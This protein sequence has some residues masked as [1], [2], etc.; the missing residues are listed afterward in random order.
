MF[1]D[2]LFVLSE[3]P[4]TFNLMIRSPRSSLKLAPKPCETAPVHKFSQF[5]FPWLD[6]ILALSCL[7]PH[8]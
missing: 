8:D 6:G 7:K 4:S 3:I 2:E 1:L 5:H